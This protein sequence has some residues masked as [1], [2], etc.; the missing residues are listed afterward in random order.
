MDERKLRAAATHILHAKPRSDSNFLDSLARIGIS[1]HVEP[2]LPDGVI[3]WKTKVLVDGRP[4][5]RFYCFDQFGTSV[6]AGDV[7][8][9]DQRVLRDGDGGRDS[10]HP[11]GTVRP[12]EDFADE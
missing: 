1:V 9:Y 10:E 4:S 11:E 6:E 8:L 5:V 7:G 12:R 3:L 2:L